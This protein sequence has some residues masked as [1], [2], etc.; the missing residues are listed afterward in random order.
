MKA[1]LKRI[2]ATLQQTG[3]IKPTSDPEPAA[4]AKTQTRPAYSFEIYSATQKRHL[5][6]RQQSS[7]ATQHTSSE[8]SSAISVQSAQISA[9]PEPQLPNFNRSSKYHRHVS[10]PI[11]PPWLEAPTDVV[12]C[13][14]H[15][16]Q[17]VHQIQ[18]IYQEGPIVNGW[19][20]SSG[21]KLEPTTQLSRESSE[22]RT[23]YVA[24]ACSFDQGR[25]T[26]ESPR[27]G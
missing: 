17:I 13:Q 6:P 12:A 24:A 22:Y 18:T 8:D 14:K 26:C 19:L 16:Q 4:T 7:H 3:T 23:E 21:H 11:R 9:H 25:V 10:R 2:E 15:L 20:E 5:P 1:E 27:A